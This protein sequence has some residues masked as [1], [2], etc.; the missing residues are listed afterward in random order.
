MSEN[1]RDVA[2]QRLI[3]G[4]INVGPRFIASEEKNFHS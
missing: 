4:V 3:N 2:L 1:C